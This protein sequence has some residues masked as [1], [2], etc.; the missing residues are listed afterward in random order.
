MTAVTTLGANRLLLPLAGVDA[1]PTISTTTGITTTQFNLNSGNGG[2]NHY[3]ALGGSSAQAAAGTS[4][5]MSYNYGA[6]QQWATVLLAVR[7]MPLPSV[8]TGL[9]ATGGLSAHVP[10][11]WNSATDATVYQ[12]RHRVNG[13]G[14]WTQSSWQAGTSL[15]MTSLTNGT[16]YEFQVKA[17]NSVGESAWSSSVTATPST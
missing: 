6:N 17:R 14:A 2:G 8:P 1:K 11:T 9:A 13:A 7:P 15:D 3:T 10:L 5:A 12:V 16:S 4:A